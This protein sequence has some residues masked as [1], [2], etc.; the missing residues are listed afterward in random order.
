MEFYDVSMYLIAVLA[1]AV[2]TDQVIDM[3]GSF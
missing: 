1:R 2:S 3:R